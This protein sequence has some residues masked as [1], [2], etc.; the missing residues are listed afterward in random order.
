[1]LTKEVLGTPLLVMIEQFIIYSMIG[2]LVESTYMSICNKKLTNR[3]FGIGPFCPIYGFGAVIGNMLLSPF[4]FHPI[5]MYFVGAISA[6][7][8]EFIVAKLMR[9]LFNEVWW[10]YNNKPFNYQ[11]I[12]CLESTIAW[13]FYGLIIVYRLN[14]ITLRMVEM[15]PMQIGKIVSLVILFLYLLDF[16]YHFLDSLDYNLRQN[17][18]DKKELLVERC[19]DFIR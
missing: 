12:I 5:A 1:M 19:W 14:G 18:K 4:Y 17:L 7:T 10:D 9:Y 15:I 8:F 6:T 2:W 3:G 13:G 11:G 16:T